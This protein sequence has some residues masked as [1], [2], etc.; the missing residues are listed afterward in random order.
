M[1]GLLPVHSC[2]HQ[3]PHKLKFWIFSPQQYTRKYRSWGVKK[4]R[5][6]E[7]WVAIDHEVAKRKRAGLDS[8]V[9]D[10][11][12]LIPP[13][14]VRRETLRHRPSLRERCVGVRRLDMQRF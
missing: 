1:R 8:D 12:D 10:G 7:V 6:D 5:K 9:Y 11:D 4:F 2:P 13:E 3:Q 14:K